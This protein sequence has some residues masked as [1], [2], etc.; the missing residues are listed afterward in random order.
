LGTQ[1]IQ[2]QLKT[3]SALLPQHEDLQDS[4]KLQKK[5]LQIQLE[6]DNTPTK[7]TTINWNDQ[8]T[9]AT[10]QQKFLETKK[11]IIHF[12]D[13][14]I[15]DLEVLANVA[16]KIVYVLKEQNINKRGLKKLLNFIEK[17]N[18]FK[19]IEATL[20]ENIVPIRKAAKKLGVQPALLLYMVSVLIQPC[21]EEIARKI[22]SSLLDKWWQASC[23]VCG[24][25]PIV[26]RVRQRKRYLGCTFCGAEYLSDRFLCVYCGNKDPY[27]LKYLSV[28]SQPAFQIDFCTKCKHYVKVIDEAK[29]KE[30]IPRGLEDILTLN[31]DL[32]AKNA[33]LRRD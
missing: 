8:T 14:S 19:L 3:I 24:R 1:S 15:F 26:A 12:L 33:D 23:P 18:L 10:L 20:R 32:V 7:G 30:A 25:I 16:K 17:E 9:I 31:L 29:L 6:I 21:L 13:P 5:I 27:T 22:D 28:D 4:L 2:E 11:P